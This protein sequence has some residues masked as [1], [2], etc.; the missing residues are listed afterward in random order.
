MLA[1]SRWMGK[2]LWMS[3]M[4][5]MA[6]EGQELWVLAQWANFMRLLGVCVCVCLWA[7]LSV[8]PPTS[9]CPAPPS[10]GNPTA[11]PALAETHPDSPQT[12][13]VHSSR[14]WTR[15]ERRWSGWPGA[16]ELRT[17]AHLKTEMNVADVNGEGIVASA[18]ARSSLYLLCTP[19]W[20]GIHPSPGGIPLEP[21]SAHPASREVW[22]QQ[23]HITTP[24]IKQTQLI[25]SH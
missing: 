6:C 15:R 13:P 16:P 3:D 1:S 18:V 8:S 4:T 19:E 7:P 5:V 20:G 14:H 10:C 25:I 12:L 21:E 11:P 24:V 17:T 22:D 9:L 2:S 23:G